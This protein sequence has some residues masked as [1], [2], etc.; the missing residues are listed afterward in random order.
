M[1]ITIH[2]LIYCPEQ[3]ANQP[4]A[5]RGAICNFSGMDFILPLAGAWP[6]HRVVTKRPP[7]GSL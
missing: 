3:Q 2:S 1:P 5:M 4:A 7:N 6:V